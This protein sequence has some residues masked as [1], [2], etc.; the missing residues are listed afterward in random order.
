MGHGGSDGG[1]RLRWGSE[2]PRT[3]L[4][5]SWPGG[6]AAREML[7]SRP[8]GPRRRR[9]DST[10]GRA[11][12]RNSVELE[13]PG[14]LRSRAGRL[15]RCPHRSSARTAPRLLGRALADWLRSPTNGGPP[16]PAS[17]AR[18]RCGQL[19]GSGRRA[20][21]PRGPGP[22]PQPSRHP[23]PRRGGPSSRPGRRVGS[24]RSSAPALGAW[25]FRAEVV[26][27]DSQA[28]AAALG[29]L[30]AQK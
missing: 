23:G 24:G 1:K 7:G 16:P 3:R 14:P 18:G 15:A 9:P 4:S 25:G 13:P 22:P 27:V 20:P 10:V 28:S 12:P 17:P 21:S 2:V 6:V 8:S 5:R 11:V 29:A 19:K 26:H 30:R